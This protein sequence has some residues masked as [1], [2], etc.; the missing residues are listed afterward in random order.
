[1]RRFLQLASQVGALQQVIVELEKVSLTVEALNALLFQCIELDA[2]AEVHAIEQIG[3]RQGVVFNCT[4]YS[5]LM[6]VAPANTVLDL[7]SDAIEQ[8]VRGTRH[9]EA[10]AKVAAERQDNAI[11]NMVLQN[12][13]EHP[14]LPTLIALLDVTASCAPGGVGSEASDA[15]V[16]QLFED[17]FSSR[18]LSSDI[19]GW[20]F[21]L[22]AATRRGRHDLVARL[23]APPPILSA[24]LPFAGCLGEEGLKR[25]ASQEGLPRSSSAWSISSKSTRASSEA[26]TSP[27]SVAS[28]SPSSVDVSPT[29]LHVN[30][31][32]WSDASQFFTARRRCLSSPTSNFV[33]PRGERA[34]CA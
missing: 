20:R 3:R 17:H 19:V 31:H 24:S 27:L 23:M 34:V 26:A 33:M 5:R 6:R 18:D 4:T 1:L 16:L 15:A 25:A 32:R 9:F 21:V 10:A 7:L 12:I 11:A 22:E 30:P 29:P 13:P 2:V 8:G 14:S 28:L